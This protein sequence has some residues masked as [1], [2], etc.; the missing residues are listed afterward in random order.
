[1]K[2]S[3]ASVVSKQMKVY[4]SKGRNIEQFDFIATKNNTGEWQDIIG[5][6]GVGIRIEGSWIL[7]YEPLDCGKRAKNRTRWTIKAVERGVVLYIYLHTRTEWE[8]KRVLFLI[9]FQATNG[10]L[11]NSYSSV[12]VW[13]FE[14]WNIK[15]LSE[16]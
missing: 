14:L 6:Y 11:F 1:V 5:T 10:A 7:G 15:N 4:Q 12:T 16:S 13:G 3:C 2:K 9:V 8:T